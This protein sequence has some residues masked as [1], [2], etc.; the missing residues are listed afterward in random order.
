MGTKSNKTTVSFHSLGCFKNLVDTEVLGGLLE[1]NNLQLV[2]PYEGSDWIVINTCGFIR[3]AKEE[4]IDSILEALE[5]KVQGEIKHVAV[6]GCLTER[7]YNDLIE[8]FKDA[9]ILW[10]VNDL[11]TLAGMIANI[12]ESEKSRDYKKTDRGLFLYNDSYKRII[13]TTPN[14]TFIKISEGCNMTCSFCA[15]PQIRGQ[16]RSREISSIIKEAQKYK[17][18]GFEEIN[19]IS[20]NSTYFGKDRGKK[21]ELPLL[22]EEISKV[23]LKCV[24]VLYLMPEEITPEIIDAFAHPSIAPY[25]DLPFQHVSEPVLKRMNRGGNFKKNLQLI[26]TIRKKYPEAVIRSS[27]IVG[28][29]GETEED[30]NELVRFAQTAVIERIGVFGYSDEENTPAFDLGDKLTEDVIE[31]RRELLMDISDQNIE[32][33]N[34]S[35][36]G[37]EQYFLPLGPWDNNATIGRILSQGPDTDGLTR[38]EVP[39]GDYYKMYPIK[40]T[41]F[42][43]ELLNGEEL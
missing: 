4:S 22:L 25:F 20:Q 9:D 23:G 3:A 5:K 15:I 14:V 19:L 38:V 28:F 32:A 36:V 30:F 33:Y 17:D 26:E 29:P 18:M 34:E 43:N 13:T 42:Q 21:S 40:I 8:E 1:K 16:Y 10:G 11:E 27:F 6:F 24:R 31:L 12:D 41:G 35:L 2:S 7:Y 37:T 39:F